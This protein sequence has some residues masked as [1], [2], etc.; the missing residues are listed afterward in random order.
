MTFENIIT[1]TDPL[2]NVITFLAAKVIYT[3]VIIRDFWTVTFE[4]TD[5]RLS[6][7][8]SLTSLRILIFAQ[9]RSLITALVCIRFAR[10]SSFQISRKLTVNW[11]SL[12]STK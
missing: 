7:Y 11:K 2:V 9:P 3:S 10:R 8:G 6:V 1:L 4:H 5:L 12:Y